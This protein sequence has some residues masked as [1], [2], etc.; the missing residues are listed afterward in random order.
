[1]TAVLPRDHRRGQWTQRIDEWQVLAMV[2]VLCTYSMASA[3]R[4]EPI[5]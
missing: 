4:V 5:R 1:M 3:P 2:L